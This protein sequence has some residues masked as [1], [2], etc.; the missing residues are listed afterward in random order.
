MIEF[1]GTLSGFL[2]KLTQN[3]SD[4]RFLVTSKASWIKTKSLLFS[5]S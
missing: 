3:S 2:D 1:E 4:A 5:F